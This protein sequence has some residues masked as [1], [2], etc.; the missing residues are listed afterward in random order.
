VSEAEALRH[1]Q[2][3][4]NREG[5]P[6]KEPVRVRR[7]W[8]RWLVWTNADKIGGNVEVIVDART[9]EARRRWGPVSR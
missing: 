1:A 7:R 8:G 5:L 3:L 2:D 4:C 9:G 6:W